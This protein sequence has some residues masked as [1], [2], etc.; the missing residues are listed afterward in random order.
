M[1]LGDLLGVDFH[2][3]SCFFVG[4]RLSILSVGSEVCFLMGLGMKI[5]DFLGISWRTQAETTRSGEG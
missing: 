4:S 5:D 1:D 3:F 2:E